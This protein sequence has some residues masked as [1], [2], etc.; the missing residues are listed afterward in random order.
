M[1]CLSATDDSLHLIGILDGSGQV[2]ITIFSDEDVVLNADTS[3]GPVLVQHLK[4]NIWSVDWVAQVWLDDE[5]AEVDLSML[6]A[7]LYYIQM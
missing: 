3:N 7:I 6:V 2:I 1:N 5:L 4:V